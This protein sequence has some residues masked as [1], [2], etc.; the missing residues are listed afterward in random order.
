MVLERR[1]DGL[2]GVLREAGG[3]SLRMEVE[4]V[5]QALR[6]LRTEWLQLDEGVIAS[7]VQ[8]LV[9]ALVRRSREDPLT[10]VVLLEHLDLLEELERWPGWGLRWVWVRSHKGNVHHNRAHGAAYRMASKVRK[11]SDTTAPST[12]TPAPWF[13]S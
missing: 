13:T 2:G 3:W 6:L 5:L 4:A 12:V 7:D 1:K 11:A 10:G 9:E 8:A